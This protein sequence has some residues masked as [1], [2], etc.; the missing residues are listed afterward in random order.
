MIYG[1]D[2]NNSSPA[3]LALLALLAVG[4]GAE[5]TPISPLEES[6]TAQQQVLHSFEV[7]GVELT[8]SNFVSADGTEVVMMSERG[9]AY[10]RPLLST[11]LQQEEN[12]TSLEA[13]LALVADGERPHELLVAA[14]AEEATAMGR[15]DVAI[16]RLAFEPERAIEKISPSACQAELIRGW[17]PSESSFF[18]AKVS[19]SGFTYNC[20]GNSC[21]NHT[22]NWTSSVVCNDSNV[23]IEERN[24]WRFPGGSW[25]NTGFEDLAVEQYRAWYMPSG[26]DRYYSADGLSPAGKLY[27]SAVIATQPQIR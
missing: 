5:D 8:V 18:S 7:A 16:Q 13:F 11:L 4:C 23:E 3:L 19:V 12:L 20:L 26:V 27:H 22:T 17:H 10:R 6:E 2:V 15:S 1:N 14:H 25:Q 9:S 24:A 21:A